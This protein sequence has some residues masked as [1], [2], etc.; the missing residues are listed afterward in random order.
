VTTDAIIRPVIGALEAP[1]PDDRLDDPRVTITLEGP[2]VD[3]AYVLMTIQNAI[4]EELPSGG[5]TIAEI[6]LRR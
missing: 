2:A 1:G 3:L 5:V 4:E 6:A